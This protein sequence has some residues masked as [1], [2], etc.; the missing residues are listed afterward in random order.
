MKIERA[1]ADLP[2]PYISLPF[3]WACG[4]RP[5]DGH[6][7]PAPIDPVMLYVH[8]PVRFE[9]HAVYGCSLEG[10]IDSVI[11]GKQNPKSG[12]VAMQRVA[13]STPR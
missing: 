6:G 7:G 8:V 3:R 12:K 9:E 4:D 1:I 10:V 13:P 11:D 2:P 5:S